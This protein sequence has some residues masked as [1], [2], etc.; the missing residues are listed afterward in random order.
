ME[1]E[2]VNQRFLI[3]NRVPECDWRNISIMASMNNVKVY[4]D[5]QYGKL[6][7]LTAERIKQLHCFWISKS[8]VI[9]ASKFE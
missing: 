4:L 8:T 9:Y 7:L 2:D 3:K 5:K 1:L 6:D